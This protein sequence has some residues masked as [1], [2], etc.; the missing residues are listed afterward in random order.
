MTE[1]VTE[2]I[3]DNLMN[4]IVNFPENN[5]C[6]DCGSKNPSW[7]SAY[8]GVNKQIKKFSY[9]FALN[10]QEDIEVMAHIFPL[11]VQLI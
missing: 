1:Y 2:D 3:R 8:L 11:F 6:F 9:L 7:A 4:K 10:A 5:I